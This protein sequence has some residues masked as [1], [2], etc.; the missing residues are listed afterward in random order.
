MKDQ[1]AQAERDAN[2][3]EQTELLRGIL[4]KMGLF[5]DYADD[6][7][8]YR[9][10]DAEGNVVRNTVNPDEQPVGSNIHAEEPMEKTPEGKPATVEN[11]LNELNKTEDEALKQQVLADE[12]QNALQ[13]MQNELFQASILILSN[14]TLCKAHQTAL[15]IHDGSNPLGKEIIYQIQPGLLHI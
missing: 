14:T 1:M 4:D 5:V 6:R 7:G 9:L 2:A 3:K 12:K 10:V 15:R 13:E 11:S 8:R